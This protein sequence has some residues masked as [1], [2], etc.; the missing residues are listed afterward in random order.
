MPKKPTTVAG[1]IPL[2]PERNPRHWNTYATVSDWYRDFHGRVPVDTALALKRPME[3]A[4]CRFAE[5]YKVLLDAR[6]IIVINEDL[7]GEPKTGEH[8]L[9]GCIRRG[10]RR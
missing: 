1:G 9:R 10:R 2:L 3:Q 6:L 5:A 7:S 4:S 8:S